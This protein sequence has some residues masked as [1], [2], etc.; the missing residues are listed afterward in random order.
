MYNG[1]WDK[2]TTFTMETGPLIEGETP[3]TPLYVPSSPVKDLLPQD[4]EEIPN[5]EDLF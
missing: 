3:K 5:V 1:L 4:L 2:E